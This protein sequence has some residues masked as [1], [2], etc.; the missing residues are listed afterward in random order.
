MMEVRIGD[1]GWRCVRRERCSSDVPD[2]RA[3]M[4]RKNDSSGLKRR[5]EEINSSERCMGMKCE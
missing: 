2:E 3:C 1:S 4:E 5:Q